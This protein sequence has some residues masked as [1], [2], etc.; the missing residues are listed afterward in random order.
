MAAQQMEVTKLQ[1]QRIDKMVQSGSLPKG[2]LL[3]LEAQL[4]D[5]ELQLVQ[6]ENQ[7]TLSTLNLLQ[8]LQLDG[9]FDLDIVKPIL[10]ST[11]L[12]MEDK[13]PSEIYNASL[14]VMPEIKSAEI[15][16]ES[17]MKNLSIA[18]ASRSPF[19]SMGASVGTG[20]SESRPDP[21]FTQLG[22]NIYRNFGISLSIPI[23]TKYS[24]QNNVDQA[25]LQQERANYSLLLEKQQLR[26]DVESAYADAE[27]ALKSFYANRKSMEALELSFEYAQK[28]FDAGLINSVDYNTNKNNLRQAE[29]QLLRSKYEYIFKRKILDFFQGKEIRL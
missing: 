16:L 14:G 19:L 27:A 26:N 7:I 28:R 29:S 18:R 3:E 23:F 21:Y 8:L 22:D 1:I 9:D 11:E 5:E 6:S 17:S 10:D 24:I 4:A 15:K 25:R 12:A 2:N 13:R 20:Y